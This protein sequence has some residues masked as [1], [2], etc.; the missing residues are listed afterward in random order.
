MLVSVAVTRALRLIGVLSP[1]EAAAAE[2]MVTGV[3][4]L[5]SMLFGWIIDGIDLNHATVAQ[6]DELLIDAPYLDTVIHALASR[7]A[8]EFG[9]AVD[10][11]VLARIDAIAE[12]GKTLLRS[13]FETPNT[14]TVPIDLRQGS[15]GRRGWWGGA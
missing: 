1:T 11:G 7:L 2:D 8:L 6:A 5:N 9:A 4:V 3:E 15:L 14:M 10:G 12:G 13:R